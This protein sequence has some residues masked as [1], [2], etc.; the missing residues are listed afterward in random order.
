MLTA[1]LFPPIIRG[2]RNWLNRL[3]R[4]ADWKFLAAIAAMVAFILLVMKFY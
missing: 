4:K 2:M 1:I 3:L